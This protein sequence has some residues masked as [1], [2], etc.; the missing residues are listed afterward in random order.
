LIAHLSRIPPIQLKDSKV[1]N[2]LLINIATKKFNEKF[3]GLSSG[4][5]KKFQNLY[6]QDES[7]LSEEYK[8]NINE[9]LNKLDKLIGDTSDNDL[10]I[11]LKETKHKI[12]EG[13]FSKNSLLKIKELNTTIL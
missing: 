12:N 1:P 7:S 9:T 2:S 8:K 4:D 3:N 10:I 6:S 13:T 5:K 11:K